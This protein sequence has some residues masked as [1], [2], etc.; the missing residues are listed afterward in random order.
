MHSLRIMKS[1]SDGLLTLG[2]VLSCVLNFF[3]PESVSIVSC[4]S[5]CVIVFFTVVTWKVMIKRWPTSFNNIPLYHHIQNSEQQCQHVRR[6]WYYVWH[7]AYMFLGRWNFFPKISCI[8]WDVSYT[9]GRF[10]VTGRS[11]RAKTVVRR[12]DKNKPALVNRHS[13]CRI[14]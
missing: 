6:V 13:E 14:P 3:S 9:A 11:L 10:A 5:L 8:N 12:S 2:V 1:V 4:T 7:R